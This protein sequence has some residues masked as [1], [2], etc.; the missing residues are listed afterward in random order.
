M[1]LSFGFGAI[2]GE[3]TDVIGSGIGPRQFG[4]LQ[5][6]GAQPGQHC[7]VTY[8]T[9]SNRRTPDI[10]IAS[11]PLTAGA[12]WSAATG[13]TRRYCCSSVLVASLMS[14]CA[15]ATVSAPPKDLDTSPMRV[16]SL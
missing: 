8:E 2:W 4:V 10:I 13:A 12:C 6:S 1:Q 7:V 3:R 15:Y 5:A 9:R 14:F 11:A 16:R